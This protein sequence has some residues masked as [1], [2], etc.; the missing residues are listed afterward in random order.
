MAKLRGGVVY[1]TIAVKTSLPHHGWKE[2][3][4]AESQVFRRKFVFEKSTKHKHRY[5][6][7]IPESNIELCGTLY[8]TKNIGEKPPP[9]VELE[10][11]IPTD[12][13]AE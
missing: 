2:Y 8:V 5:Q 4:L 7:V 12:G 11:I 3:R 6:E 13:Q 10:L 9:S 1:A